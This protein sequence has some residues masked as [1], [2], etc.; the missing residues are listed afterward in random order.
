LAIG[1]VDATIAA[2]RARMSEAKYIV[3]VGESKDASLRLTS[4]T[5]G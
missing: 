5:P 1:V 2:E 4:R 3:T